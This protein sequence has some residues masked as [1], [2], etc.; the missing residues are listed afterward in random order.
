MS[1]EK[2]MMLVA[3]DGVAWMQMSPMVTGDLT[4]M[5]A[6]TKPFFQFDPT[7]SSESVMH[8]NT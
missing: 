4:I 1:L 5:V 2:V 6:K 7:L 3:V 8:I